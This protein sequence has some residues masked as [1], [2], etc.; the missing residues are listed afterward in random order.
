MIVLCLGMQSSGS[1]WLYNIVREI[2]AASGVHHVA[3]R[4]ENYENF[5]D[6]RAA[7]ADNAVLRAHNVDS[8]LLRILKLADVK[9]VLSFRD[10]RDAIASFMQRFQPYGAKFPRIC[11]D[12]ARNL[13]SVLSASQHFDHL[14]FFY[15][16]GFTDDPGSVRR[17]AG[18]L[19]YELHEDQILAIFDKYRAE[20]VKAFTAAI[21]TL[22]EDRLFVDEASNAM[23]RVTSF[24]RTHISDMR[25]GKWRDVFDQET[26]AALTEAFGDYARLLAERA[27][28]PGRQPTR[29]PSVLPLG[30]VTVNFSSRLFAP[31]DNPDHFTRFLTHRELL[32]DLGIRCLEYLYLPEGEWE[33]VLRTKNMSGVNAKFCQNGTVIHEQRSINGVVSFLYINRL[34]DHPFDV[35]LTCDFKCDAL[36]A[37]CFPM[38]FVLAAKLLRPVRSIVA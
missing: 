8:G 31:M 3:Y 37:D 12:V 6:P 16:D 26:Q 15:E 38:R 34:H 7:E 9:A 27:T 21:D 18:F 17:L 32:G 2:L 30:A 35:H 4:A 10:P 24:H 25:V 5:L 23:D 33:F 13:A 29:N 14:S 19:G 22:P 20:T 36:M 28:G 11:N 1:T